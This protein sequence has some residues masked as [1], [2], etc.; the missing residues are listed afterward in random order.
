MEIQESFWVGTEEISQIEI[1]VIEMPL[2]CELAALKVIKILVQQKDGT[3]INLSSLKAEANIFNRDPRR[4]HEVSLRYVNIEITSRILNQRQFEF[5]EATQRRRSELRKLWQLCCGICQNRCVS[6]CRWA[7][8]QD[9]WC[10]VWLLEWQMCCQSLQT[11]SLSTSSRKI[12]KYIIH[13]KMNRGNIYELWRGDN[14][15]RSENGQRRYIRVMRG[16]HHA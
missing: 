2:C 16:A 6:F 10:R 8:C 12:G 14:H 7:C 1:L 5:W 9:F 4:V 11:W 3:W 13:A 15:G